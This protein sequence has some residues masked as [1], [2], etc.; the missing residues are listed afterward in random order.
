MPSIMPL[1]FVALLAGA[2]VEVKADFV[3][4]GATLYDGSAAAGRKADLAIRG[5]RI[6]AIG[7]FTTA[8]SPRVIDGTDLIVA[9]GFIDLTRTAT[10]PWSTKT[11][12]AIALTSRR[13][14]PP[15]SPATAASGPP[16]SGPTSRR[17]KTAASAAT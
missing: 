16:T 13:A 10:T 2:D 15:W 11:R 4:K 5:E 7:T 6:V 3:I 17:W 1:C 14:P 8:G 9:P 12:A